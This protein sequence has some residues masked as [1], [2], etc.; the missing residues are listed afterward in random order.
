MDKDEEIIDLVEFENSLYSDNPVFEVR[1]IIDIDFWVDRLV[2][3]PLLRPFFLDR[4]VKLCAEYCENLDFRDKILK[5]SSLR[6]PVLIYR[7]YCKCVLSFENIWP[8]LNQKNCFWLCYYFRKEINCFED[9]M[10]HKN[11]KKHDCFSIDDED[12]FEKMLEYGFFPSTPEY[13]LKYDD[14]DVFRGIFNSE[15]ESKELQWSPFEWSEKPG[16]FDCLS[17]SGY[18][19]SLRCFNFLIMNGF[20]LSPSVRS[21]VVCSGN[22]DLYH[23]YSETEDFAD[24]ICNAT[25]YYNMPLL[26]F[27]LERGENTNKMNSESL[28]PLHLG[29]IYGHIG[30]IKFLIQNKARIDI[31]TNRVCY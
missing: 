28:S 27:L 31:S 30:M 13:C 20:Q 7:L 14:I 29:S 11:N 24:Q 5:I 17:F 16:S 3:H 8:I 4:I 25:Q 6:C 22:F 9:F 26:M 15:L 12:A 19:G 21:I 10:I 2:T 23:M 18:F 1:E